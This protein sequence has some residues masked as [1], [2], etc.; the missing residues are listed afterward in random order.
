MRD[1]IGYVVFTDLKGFSNMKEP[2]TFYEYTVRPL[3]KSLRDHKHKALVWNTWGDALVA[4]FKKGIDAVELMLEYRDYFRKN[5]MLSLQPRISGHF[6]QMLIYN[7]PLINNMDNVLGDTINTTARI[8]PITFPGE[9]YVSDAFYENFTKESEAASDPELYSPVRFTDLK[10]WSLP[11]EHGNIHLYRLFH[12][13]EESWNINTM[14]VK[15]EKENIDSLFEMLNMDVKV[16][17]ARK[18]RH[19]VHAKTLNSRKEVEDYLNQTFEESL[20]LEEDIELNGPL[21]IALAELYRNIG[22]YKK[23]RKMIEEAQNWEMNLSYQS[24][25]QK[26]ETKYWTES[27]QQVSLSPF[28]HNIS[29]LKLKADVL[30]KDDDFTA[31]KDILTNILQ[32]NTNDTDTLNKLAAQLKRE[33]FQEN[34]AEKERNE[35]LKEALYLYLEAFRRDRD[36]YPAINAAYIDKILGNSN[37]WHLASYI[38]NTWKSDTGKDWWLDSTLA[39]TQLLLGEFK[40]CYNRMERAV[41][42]H[43][44]A[45]YERHATRD[46]IEKFIEIYGKKQGVKE[47]VDEEK[48][49]A[50]LLSLLLKDPALIKEYK[51]EILT[52]EMERVEEIKANIST[53]KSESTPHIKAV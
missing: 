20:E 14:F 3:A 45:F 12:E 28:K 34:K 26:K 2:D 42:K 36:Y 6:G 49:Y 10:T 48:R 23:A 40:F 25:Y 52:A 4:V 29:T 11:K 53:A 7:D 15:N 16:K 22:N 27:L 46:Q 21:M 47:L 44:P 33:A 9:I 17:E 18:N 37:G 5:K 51:E 13:S 35:L 41:M 31:A 43:A 38:F 39:E 50:L 24:E 8:E 30:S 32:Q 1:I 19:I